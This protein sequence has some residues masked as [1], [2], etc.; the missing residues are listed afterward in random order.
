MPVS[1]PTVACN[2]GNIILNEFAIIFR[3]S[4]NESYSTYFARSSALALRPT[5]LKFTS[6]ERSSI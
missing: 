2:S 3:S 4:S 6:P 5:T 1:P